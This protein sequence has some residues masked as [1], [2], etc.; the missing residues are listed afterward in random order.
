MANQ[1]DYT[2]QLPLK[3]TFMTNFY[4]LGK[5]LRVSENSEAQTCTHNTISLCEPQVTGRN[6]SHNKELGKR[7]F[8]RKTSDYTT[9]LPVTH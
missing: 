4:I 8:I 2:M 3:N 1:C 9:N 6:G 7:L 5:C